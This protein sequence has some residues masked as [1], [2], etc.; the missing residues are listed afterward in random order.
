MRWVKGK[1]VVKHFPKDVSVTFTAGDLVQLVTGELKT[2]TNQSIKHLGII[3][4]DIA[5]T[6]A[7]FAAGT[8]V[9][10]EIPLEPS[11][12]FEA[13]VTGTLTASSPGVTYDL[14]SA[15]VVNQAGTTYDVVT[16]V[17]FISATKGRFI[18]NSN[19]AYADPN[20]E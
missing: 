20:W 17:G 7:D 6:D 14:S 16:C 1:T 2:A 11:C 3:L 12:E 13:T 9:P 5:S 18:L 8:R 15:S 4:K 19:Q 10:V